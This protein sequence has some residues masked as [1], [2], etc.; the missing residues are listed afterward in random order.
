VGDAVKLQIARIGAAIVKHKHRAFAG[1]KI[2]FQG[3]DLSTIAQRI[4]GQQP[5]LRKAVEHDARGAQSIDAIHH[6]LDRL[7]Q[8]DLGRLQ[9]RLLSVGIKSVFAHQFEQLDVVQRPVVA[10]RHLS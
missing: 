1:R 2:M 6:P 8:F 3:Q 10:P 5:H 4:L 7:A 9:D